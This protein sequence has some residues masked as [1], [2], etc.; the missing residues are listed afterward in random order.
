MSL[1]NFINSAQSIEF[2][3]AETVATSVSRSG[4]VSTQTR[5]SVKPWTFKVIPAAYLKWDTNRA[6]I[7]SVLQADRAVEQ[8]ISL[9]ATSGSA[10]LA[11][12]QGSAPS[13]AGVLDTITAT[14][15]S[16]NS[17]TINVAGVADDTIIFRTGDIIQPVGHRYPYVVQ[18]DV[19]KVT[20]EDSASVTLHR[21]YLAQSG[22]TLTGSAIA[23]G[24]ACTFRVVA[25]TLPNVR[26]LPGQLVEFTSEMQLLEVVL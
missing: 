9:G 19:V 6:A 22:Y 23:V 15:A 11:Q 24:G 21:G 10:W 25:T 1:Q 3:R 18:A 17:L 5:N 13:T 7:E 16:G 12:Y 2:G 20:D 4:R 8:T 26:Y 14:S